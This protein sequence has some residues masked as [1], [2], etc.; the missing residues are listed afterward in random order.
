[1]QRATN[2]PCGT[3]SASIRCRS[4]KGFGKRRD[5]A[6]DASEARRRKLRRAARAQHANREPLERPPALIVAAP[7]WRHHLPRSNKF[8]HC[9]RRT[10]PSRLKAMLIRRQDGCC[11]DCTIAVDRSYVFDHRPPLALRE[12]HSD[13]NDP[14]LLAVICQDCNK[15][16][17]VRDFRDRPVQATRFHVLRASQPR[18]DGFNAPRHQAARDPRAAAEAAGGRARIAR[19]PRRSGPLGA[20]EGTLASRKPLSTRGLTDRKLDGL[21]RRGAGTTPGAKPASSGPSRG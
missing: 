1:M 12:V 3:T 20:R 18:A 4:R 9:Q 10:L 2:R 13:A 7:S 15:A 14:N 6:G 16:K 19:P 17:T 8:P 21:H 11:A 5:S